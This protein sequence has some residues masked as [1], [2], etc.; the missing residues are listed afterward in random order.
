MRPY[1]T[2]LESTQSPPLLKGGAPAGGGG[3]PTCKAALYYG[4]PQSPPQAV[5]GGF[6]YFNV[7]NIFREMSRA[8]SMLAPH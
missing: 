6:F 2:A 5:A 1:R 4:I 8:C 3:I 7:S